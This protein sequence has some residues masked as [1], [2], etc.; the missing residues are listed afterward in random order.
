MLKTDGC[1]K[2]NA[3]VLLHTNN[4]ACKAIMPQ[5]LKGI[6]ESYG[7]SSHSENA[8][9]NIIAICLVINAGPSYDMS[10]Q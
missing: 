10:H 3:N 2:Q 8:T 4:M 5:N 7:H 6:D 9:T 1:Y